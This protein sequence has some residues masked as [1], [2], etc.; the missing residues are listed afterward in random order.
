MFNAMKIALCAAT[1][2][3]LMFTSGVR[4][5]VKIQGA[6]GTFPQ[7]LYVKWIEAYKKLHPDVTIDYQGVGS[8]AGINAITGKTVQFGAS[9]APMTVAQEKTANNDIIHLPTVAGPVVLTFNV[10]GVDKLTLSGDVIGG[11][12]LGNIKNWD[13]RKLAA[14]NPGVKF[15]NLKIVVAH[16]ADGSGT[17]YIFTD[18]LSKVSKDWDD[19]VGA[20]TAVE[21][22]AGVG[23]QKNDGVAAAVKGTPGGIGY[24][25]LGYADKNKLPYA[26]LINQD[27]KSATASIASVNA[28][29]GNLG[30]FPDNLK[31][32]INDSK[33]ADSYPICGYTYL[34]LYKDLGYMDK[35]Q[36][37]ATVDFIRWCE[38]DGQE[39]AGDNGYAKLPKDGQEKVLAKLKEIKY[40]GEALK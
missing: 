16:R 14:I 38:T 1:A 11:I 2:A 3:V 30:G 28:A 10:P 36:A 24:V 34:L 37:Q 21:W 17:S 22:P 8:G 32:S 20:G 18:Y 29:A 27:G 12:Y 13:D 15:P 9:D 25:E 19:K 39:M 7:P 6:G 23:G 4:A 35:D 5:D 26:T 31:L 33:G 40:K